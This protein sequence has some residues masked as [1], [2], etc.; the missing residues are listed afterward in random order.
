MFAKKAYTFKE[1]SPNPRKKA[2]SPVTSKNLSNRLNNA[3]KKL[4]NE[5]NKGSG[6]SEWRV[7]K[8]LKELLRVAG[9][10]IER[11]QLESKKTPNTPNSSPNLS[12]TTLAKI[13]RELRNLQNEVNLEELE[14][15][16][17]NGQI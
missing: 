1:G 11:L 4:Q 10:Y 17:R 5:A 12:P 8:L 6:A 15:M 14:R 9:A 13:N 7:N 3:T 16:I 2:A